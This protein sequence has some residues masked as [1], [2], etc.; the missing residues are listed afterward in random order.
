MS[1]KPA[2][3]IALVPPEPFRDRAWKLKEHFRDKFNSKAS[4]NSPPHITLVPPFKLI[5]EEEELMEALKKK[6]AAFRPFEVCL[7]N[8]GAFPPRVIFIDVLAQPKMNEL[9]E[10][11]DKLIFEF[12]EPDPKKPKGRPFHP[13]MTL[14]FRD[15]Q[16]EQFKK[17]WQEFNEREL[18]Y[19]WEAEHF[20]L[21]RH[22]GKR[23]EELQEFWLG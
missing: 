6:A 7:E 1:S 13:H 4:L 14:A 16:K 20:T 3:F 22:N 9:Q 8:Y 18:S 17:A 2:Y 10:E 15:L 11:L 23:W 12:A 21:L 19:C 5:G